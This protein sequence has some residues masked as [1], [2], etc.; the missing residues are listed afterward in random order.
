MDLLR[1]KDVCARTGLS[2]QAI[3][4]YVEQGLVEPPKKTGKT[5]A[6]YSEAQVERIL[7]V[8]KLQDEHFLPLKAIRA[9]LEGGVSLTDA[10]RRA[11]GDVRARLSPA[12]VAIETGDVEV[13]ALL[14]RTKLSRRDVAELEHAGL[15]QIAR[16]SGRSIMPADQVWIV[17]LWGKVRAAGFTRELVGPELLVL[18]EKGIE[19]M[20]AAEKKILARMTGALP[21]ERVA[22]MIERA[23]PLIHTFLVRSHQ[24]KVRALFATVEA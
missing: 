24:T 2:R 23:L 12:T 22:E 14:R 17:E 3:H 18:F 13:G 20:F 6:Y 15:I 10:Q 1:V 11:L 9:M 19:Q 7:L 4:F 16:G 8:R 21:P 5:M